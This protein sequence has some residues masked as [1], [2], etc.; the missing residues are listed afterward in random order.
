MSQTGDEAEN[1]VDPTAEDNA[2][3]RISAFVS[4]W[5]PLSEVHTFGSLSYSDFRFL[6]A[7]SLSENAAHWLQLL[8]VGW[9]MLRLTDGAQDKSPSCRLAD[10]L[11]SP[12]LGRD[13][14]QD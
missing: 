4:R 12:Q 6:W 2:G 13:C 11:E 5:R 14:S 1:G 8:T 7:G 9:L 3:G 10:N